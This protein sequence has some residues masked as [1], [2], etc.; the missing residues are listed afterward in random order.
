MFAFASHEA[1]GVLLCVHRRARRPTPTSKTITKMK[2]ANKTDSAVSA[3]SQKRTR[4]MRTWGAYHP[5]G[6]PYFYGPRWRCIQLSK[7]HGSA[8]PLN[9]A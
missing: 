1:R 3:V 8:R 2:T 5:N 9:N 6:K 7:N 4:D